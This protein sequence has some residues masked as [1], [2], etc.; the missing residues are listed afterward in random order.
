MALVGGAVLIAGIAMLVLPGQAFL[1]IP[2]G[3]AILSFEF[4]WPRRWLQAV[5]E[6]LKRRLGSQCDRR[7]ADTH[8]SVLEKFKY[9][10]TAFASGLVFVVALVLFVAT[11]SLLVIAGA[12]FVVIPALLGILNLEFKG[13]RRRHRN[14][15]IV[16][17]RT[18]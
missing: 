18:K 8:L 14:T 3:L 15:N 10:L 11:Y 1:A 13:N 17:S 6:Y 4:D 5:R 2:A 9:R 16:L 12:A 7:D